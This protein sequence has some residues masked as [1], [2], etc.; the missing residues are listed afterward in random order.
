MQG[1]KLFDTKGKSPV[2]GIRVRPDTLE[3]MK[4]FAEKEEVTVSDILRMMADMFV[5]D[6]RGFMEMVRKRNQGVAELKVMDSRPS[7]ER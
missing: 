7:S 5:D 6:P 1:K 2:V 4:K 3:R